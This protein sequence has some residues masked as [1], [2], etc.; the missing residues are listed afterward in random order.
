MSE[1]EEIEHFGGDLSFNI[2]EFL[3]ALFVPEEDGLD[4]AEDE[5]EDDVLCPGCGMSMEEFRARQRAGCPDCY[6]VFRKEAYQFLPQG[7]RYR[8]SVPRRF[9]TVKRILMDRMRLKRS[10]EHA[11]RNRTTDAAKRFRE[12]L[13][14]WT[15]TVHRRTNF[16]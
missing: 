7:Y 3:Q 2:E 1:S 16:L 12:R 14:E 10:L 15:K 13:R 11:M 4:D 5:E 9:N 6:Y 8:G